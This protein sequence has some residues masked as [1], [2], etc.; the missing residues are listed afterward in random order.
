MSKYLL[1][2]LP[3]VII[4]VLL[5]KFLCPGVFLQAHGQGCLF[6]RHTFHHTIYSLFFMLLIMAVPAMAQKSG[7]KPFTVVIDAGHGGVDP[8]ALGKKSQEKNINFNVS[9]R[10]GQLIKE[11]SCNVICDAGNFNNWWSY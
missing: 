3:F 4:A 10:L 11:A 6:M 9:D 1:S 2:L 8:G 5:Q 7:K